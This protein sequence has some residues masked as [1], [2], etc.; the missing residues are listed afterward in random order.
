MVWKGIA[1]EAESVYAQDYYP[2]K[3]ARYYQLNAVNRVVEAVTKGQSRI[4][5]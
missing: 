5:S 1:L 2:G 3:E 4:P